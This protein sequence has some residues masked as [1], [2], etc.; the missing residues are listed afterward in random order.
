MLKVTVERNS[1][2]AVKKSI[3]LDYDESNMIQLAAV[4]SIS[5]Y[6]STRSRVSN[7]SI[8]KAIETS[9]QLITSEDELFSYLSYT[10]FKTFGF[11]SIENESY[12]V[13][14][15]PEEYSLSRSYSYQL[16]NTS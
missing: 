13:M 12:L 10:K 7:A 4:L 1:L 9:E 5:S 6:P 2:S 8:L 14:L 11:F 3:I 16:I 15:I